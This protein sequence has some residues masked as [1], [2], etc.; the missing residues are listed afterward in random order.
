MVAGTTYCG[1]F[2]FMKQERSAGESD[3]GGGIYDL[4]V[5]MDEKAI[6]HALKLF[7]I[8][9]QRRT[10][11]KYFF[12]VISDKFLQG[13]RE[14]PVTDDSGE[15]VDIFKDRRAAGEAFTIGQVKGMEQGKIYTVHYAGER[16][17]MLLSQMRDKMLERLR[18]EGAKASKEFYQIGHLKDEEEKDPEKIIQNI[19]AKLEEIEKKRKK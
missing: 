15:R 8:G 1:I 6:P 10:F 3:P 19:L 4:L 14:V 18:R 17:L 12:K 9:G 13:L 5:K 2:Q 16:D 7:A 11:N